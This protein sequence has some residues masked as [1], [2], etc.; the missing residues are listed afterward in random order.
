M[1]VLVDI[2]FDVIHHLLLHISRTIDRVV[3]LAAMDAYRVDD[4][5]GVGA[6]PFRL[7]S[8]PGVV[9]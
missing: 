6:Y 1:T 5:L 3:D 4:H 8:R 7:T 2:G 9:L